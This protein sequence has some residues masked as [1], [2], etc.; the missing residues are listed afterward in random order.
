M[1]KVTKSEALH[2]LSRTRP[3]FAFWC[4]DGKIFSDI[5]ELNAGLKAIHP[6]TF[7]YHANAQKNDFSKWVAEVIKD[8]TLASELKR[9]KNKI[10]AAKKVGARIAYLNRIVK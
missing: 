1:P 6:R 8:K 3:E 4:R 5:A 2:F 7:I 10:E 9:A